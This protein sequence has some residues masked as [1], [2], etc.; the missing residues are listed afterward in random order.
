MRRQIAIFL[1]VLVSLLFSGCGKDSDA[2]SAPETNQEA[3]PW[4]TEGFALPGTLEEDPLWAE[5]YQPWEHEIVSGEETGGLGR[6]A[7]GSRGELIWYFGQERDADGEFVRGSEGN[8]YLEIYDTGNGESEVERFSLKSLGLESALGYLCD[9]DLYD[10]GHYVFRFVDYERDEEGVCRQTQDKMIFTDLAGD[11]W[12]LELWPFYLEKEIEQESL[13]NLA[14]EFLGAPILQSVS[15]GLSGKDG[16][17]VMY[18]GLAG[19]C[20]LD[21]SGNILLE[22]EAPDDRQPMEP[23]RTSDGELIFPVY[24]NRGKNYDFLWADM[25]EG[26]LRSLAVTEAAAPSISR[27]YGMLGDDIYYRSSEGTG[28]AIVRWNIRDGRRTQLFS[29]RTAGIETGYEILLALRE[30]QTPVLHLS[31]VQDGERREWIAA[32]TDQ[33]PAEEGA[34]RVADLTAFRFNSDIVESCTQSASLETPSF[35]YEYE[36]ASEK[37]ARDRIFAELSQGKGPDLLFLD[38]EDLCLLQERGLLREIGELISPKLL[39]EL[40]PGALENGTVDGRLYGV[41]AAVRAETLAAA[42]SVWMSDTWKLEDLIGLIGEG[43]LSGAIRSPWLMGDY[44]S[45]SVAV[46]TFT[47]NC[48][49]DSFLID[50]GNRK[51]HFDDERFIRLLEYTETDHS[52]VTDETGDWLDGGESILWGYFR[53]ETDFLDFF[54]HLEKEEGRI[55]GYPTEGGCGSYLV[56]DG[57]LLAVNANLADPEAVSL[58]LGVL[59]GKEIQDKIKSNPWYLSVRKLSPEDYIVE[60][61][62]GRLLFLGNASLEIPVFEDGSTAL[63]RAKDFLE[64]CVAPPLNYT[65]L[66]QIIQEELSAMHAER[67][68][69]ETAAEIIN[70]RIQNYLDE[71]N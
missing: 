11:V 27:M 65:Q 48:L 46:T 41:P 62:S 42:E 32:L 20:L 36:N 61:G 35:S 6:W 10:R 38:R 22:Y 49:A 37:E 5:R 29:L 2:P 12:S 57:G 1:T 40:L 59:L 30:G 17:Y 56:A 50:W 9:M 31:K 45:P 43:K 71:G 34:I 55:I 39:D 70:S 15:W 67:K 60:D 26:R 69:A 58:F 33:K 3:V 24:D 64:S 23:L 7:S 63:H 16:I 47:A 21:G 28:E 44:L 54:E 14:E 19:F 52:L 53:N 18:P 68:S 66:N 51:S 25:S 8:Y 4:R 13:E